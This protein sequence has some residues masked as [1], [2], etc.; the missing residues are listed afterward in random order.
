M[1]DD[2]H[3]D[4]SK[5]VLLKRSYTKKIHDFLTSTTVNTIQ[6]VH[7]ETSNKNQTKKM[8]NFVCKA[9]KTVRMKN[10]RDT[11]DK[12]CKHQTWSFQSFFEVFFSTMTLAVMLA[13]KR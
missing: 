7:S 6:S 13:K 10:K 5:Q 11:I 9:C 3:I 8:Y 12:T 1:I 4:T 2:L